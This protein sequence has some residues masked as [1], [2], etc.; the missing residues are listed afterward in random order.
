MIGRLSGVLI[1]KQPHQVVIDVGGVG[2]LLQIPLST[3]TELGEL[4]QPVTLLVRCLLRDE[5]LQLYGF[6][7][8]RERQLFDLLIGISGV[9][10]ALALKVLSGLP[11]NELLTALRNGSADRLTAIPGIGRKTA[12]RIVVELRDRLRHLVPEPTAARPATP[13]ETDIVS[14]L[15]NLGYDRRPAESAAR[16]ALAQGATDFES[17]FRAALGVLTASRTRPAEK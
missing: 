11:V 14:A 15:I 10:P 4:D 13:L 9:G 1:D 16:A 8:A 17:A 3:Y 2:Y 5:Q 12:E 7:T 6:L